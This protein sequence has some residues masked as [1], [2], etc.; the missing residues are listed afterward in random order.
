MTDEQS[1]PR[2]EEKSMAGSQRTRRTQRRENDKTNLQGDIPELGNN[3][4]L[5]GSRNQGDS[6]IKTTEAIADYVG[7]ECSREMRL[8]V[9]NQEE[10]LPAEPKEPESSATEG[11]MTKYAKELD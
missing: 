4:Y 1:E 7:R 3:V 10:N 6:Y 11:R 2:E 8:L 5:F 9:K